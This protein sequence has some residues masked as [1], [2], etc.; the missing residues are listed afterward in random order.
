MLLADFTRL[1]AYGADGFKWLTEAVSWDGLEIT[2]VTSTVV[3]G[4]A[5]DAPADRKVP[6][7]VDVQTGKIEGGSSVAMYRARQ[8]H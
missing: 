3:E 5:W 6:F 4:L 7:R 2:R 8:A 1:A